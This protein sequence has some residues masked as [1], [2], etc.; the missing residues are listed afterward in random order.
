MWRAISEFEDQFS[1]EQLK[2]KIS[3]STDFEEDLLKTWLD[4][5]VESGEINFSNNLY[6]IS[7]KL[8]FFRTFFLRKHFEDSISINSERIKKIK[9]RGY[10]APLDNDE[11]SKVFYGVNLKYSFL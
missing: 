3:E 11:F 7:N 4:R 2:E 8:T 9:E 6:E 10:I 5:L 1:F